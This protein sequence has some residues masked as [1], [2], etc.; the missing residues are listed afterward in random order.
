MGSERDTVLWNVAVTFFNTSG[1]R[2][3]R[4]AQERRSEN[5]TSKRIWSIA[6]GSFFPSWTVIAVNVTKRNEFI[7]TDSIVVF[8]LFR[9]RSKERANNSQ[10]HDQRKI[11]KERATRKKKE[12]MRANQR[13]EKEGESFYKEALK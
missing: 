10:R 7:V 11:R 4:Q 13:I 9:L 5:R 8:V 12:A 2:V 1:E 3:G 6:S